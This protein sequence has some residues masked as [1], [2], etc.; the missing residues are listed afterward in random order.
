MFPSPCG[1]YGSY[2]FRLLCCLKPLVHSFRPLAGIMVLINSTV[3][4]IFTNMTASF[5]PLAG[6]MVLINFE[7]V[8]NV[9]GGKTFPSPCGDYGSYHAFSIE[10]R[11]CI[12]MVSVPLR[13]L[14]FLS[15]KQK[16]KMLFKRRFRPLAGIMVLIIGGVLICTLTTSHRFRPLAGIMVLINTLCN[17]WTATE[18]KTFP[19]PCGDYGSYR[20]R[21]RRRIS[22]I[23]SCFRPLAGIMVLIEVEEDDE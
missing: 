8:S 10:G 12:S 15:K 22:H 6:I 13:G 17:L 7:Q 9:L 18:V 21:G 4:S 3:T 1:D 14:W 23:E 19:S 2:P 5:R 11:K 20:S 16:R